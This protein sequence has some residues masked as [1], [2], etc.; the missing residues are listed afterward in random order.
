M[1]KNNYPVEL[2][3]NL[4]PYELIKLFP[5][6]RYIKQEIFLSLLNIKAAD[7]TFK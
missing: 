3:V 7:A 1:H 6:A 5:V 2:N 4:T